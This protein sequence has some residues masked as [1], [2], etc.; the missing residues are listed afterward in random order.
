MAR[1]W[2]SLVAGVGVVGEIFSLGGGNLG[3][4]F[5]LR[6]ARVGQPRLGSELG[7]GRLEWRLWNLKR[8][9]DFFI[10]FYVYL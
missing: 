10:L 7:T 3:T 9:S 8:E 4:G 1:R 6:G 5:G 2:G